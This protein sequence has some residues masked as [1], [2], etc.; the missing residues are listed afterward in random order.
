MTMVIIGDKSIM[1]TGG[2]NFFAGRSTG[3]QI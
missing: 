1:L 3:S 2:N